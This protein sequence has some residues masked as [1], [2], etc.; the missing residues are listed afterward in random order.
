MILTWE[1]VILLSTWWVTTIGAALWIERRL[2]RLE[3]DLKWLIEREIRRSR[4][5]DEQHHHP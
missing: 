5:S 1:A 2:S 4:Y 3:T